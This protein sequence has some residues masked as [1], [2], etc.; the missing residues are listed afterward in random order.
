MS[1]PL[2]AWRSRL[3][4]AR[5][6]A[7]LSLIE[8][9][10]GMAIGLVLLAALGSLYVTTSKARAEF[11][12]TSEQVENGRYAL[13]SITRDIEMS[14]FYGRS[15]L[16]ASVT[17]NLPDL[18][19]T[20]KDAMGFSTSG[21]TAIPVAVAGRPTTAAAP[22]CLPNLLAGTEVLTVRYASSDAVAAPTA[23]EY[24][25]Q[26][27]NC[28]LDS[29]PLVYDTSAS[30]FT[31]R[32]RTCAADKTE[33]RKYVVRSY[34]LAS[35]DDCTK[36]D[37]IPTLKVAEFVK[38]AVSVSSLV[39]GIQDI[40][41][42]YGVDQDANGSPDCYVGDPAVDNSAAC[43]LSPSYSW[44]TAAIN[45][46]NVTAIRVS[47]LSRNLDRSTGWTDSR[48][49]DLGR[50]AKDGPYTDNYKRHVYSALARVWNTGG[51]REIK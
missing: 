20:A 51:M 35:C 38:G 25:V 8:L 31:L 39:Q 30:A 32:T 13:E 36:G 18:C 15:S 19:A 47:L 1:R 11:N 21:G 44:A 41:Y 48:T 37:G 26:L 14:G 42:S 10:I 49:Y 16:G 12:K 28:R 27:S 7:G 43:T 29:A 22:A 24:Y 4:A 17:Y 23:S 40:H 33:L 50:A 6:Q 45:W 34:Y 9:M 46:A 5:R 3:L 2:P